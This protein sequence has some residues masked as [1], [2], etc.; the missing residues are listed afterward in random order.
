MTLLYEVLHGRLPPKNAGEHAPKHCHASEYPHATHPSIL[1]PGKSNSKAAS[2][3]FSLMHGQFILQRFHDFREVLASKL[4]LRPAESYRWGTGYG[5]GQRVMAC[6]C[7]GTLDP[8]KTWQ[9]L[10]DI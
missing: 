3:P 6:K 4:T 5:A 8:E 2:R 9:E 10:E 7:T 1:A